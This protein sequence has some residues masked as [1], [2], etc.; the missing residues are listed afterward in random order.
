MADFFTPLRSPNISFTAS[1]TAMS[2]IP[3]SL[4]SCGCVQ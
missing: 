4:Y 2:S 1:T 3:H